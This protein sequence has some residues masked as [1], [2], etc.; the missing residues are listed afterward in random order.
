LL[1]NGSANASLDMIQAAA[2]GIS[3]VLQIASQAYAQAD[4]VSAVEAGRVM[5][6]NIDVVVGALLSFS[7]RVASSARVISPELNITVQ[8]NVSGQLTYDT[9]GAGNASILLPASLSRQSEE[10]GPVT[11]V[12][13]T[14]LTDV[15][16]GALNASDSR[17]GPVVSFSVFSNGSKVTSFEEPLLIALP[18][19]SAGDT[20]RNCVG[21]PSGRDVF[22]QMRTGA[23]PCEASLQCKFWDEMAQEWR[24]EGCE[25]V[26]L[27][28]TD[29]AV[30]CRCTHLTDFISI[31]VPVVVQDTAV[32]LLSLDPVQRAAV[33][34]RCS[35]D[36]EAVLV[37]GGNASGTR[38]VNLTLTVSRPDL[39]YPNYTAWSAQLAP[40]SNGSLVTLLQADGTV[41]DGVPIELSP[42]S[43]GETATG[44]R[45]RATVA[46]NVTAGSTAG[47]CS[48]ISVGVRATVL[49]STAASQ[50]VWGWVPIGMPCAAAGPPAVG[51]LP[52][53]T[54]PMV[55]GEERSV[56]FTGCDY[57]GLAVQHAV[58]TPR[59]ALPDPRS[60]SAALVEL[61]SGAEL[62]VQVVSRGDG[63][64]VAVVRATRLGRTGLILTLGVDETDRV[65]AT[66]ALGALEVEV[67]CPAGLVADPAT[68]TCAC[69]AGREQ[70]GPQDGSAPAQCAACPR[71][72]FKPSVGPG[73]CEACPAG[74]RQ[75]DVAGVSCTPCIPGT[76]QPEDGQASCLLCAARTTSVAPYTECGECDAGTVRDSVKVAAS[77]EA[78]RPCHP[79][80]RCP[81]NAT[82]LPTMVLNPGVWRLAPDS[83]MLDQC[84]P[85]AGTSPCLGGGQ[86]GE[87]GAGYCRPGHSGFRC[88]VCPDG[89]YFDSGTALCTNCHTAARYTLQY[90][91]LLGSPVL[92]WLLL[93][94]IQRR[95]LWPKLN[96]A[97]SDLK[98]ASRGTDLFAKVRI[99]IGFAQVA[100]AAATYSIDVPPA[101]RV[102]LGVLSWFRL[103][104]WGEPFLPHACAGGYLVYMQLTAY[105]P[106]VLIA[107][108]G[109][110]CVGRQMWR[111]SG[112]ATAARL[113][114]L[115]A[116]GPSLAIVTMLCPTVSAA[117]FGALHCRR[118]VSS[119][120]PVEYRSFLWSS[121][122]LECDS[123]EAARLRA[124]AVAVLVV[125]PL[126][127]LV[128]LAVLLGF[129]RDAI[130]RRTPSEL[131]SAC[132]ML[133]TEV[134]L[135]RYWWGLVEHFR[136]LMLTGVLLL[137]PERM[138]FIRL[139]VALFICLS[140]LVLQPMLNPYARADVSA[141]SM[142]DQLVIFVLI[143]GYS[144]IYLFERLRLFLPT[145][146]DGSTAISLVLAFTS[147]EQ[148]AVLIVVVVST[149][150]LIVAVVVLQ[151]WVNGTRNHDF[152]LKETMR[153]PV[154]SIRKEHRFHLFLSHVWSTGQDQVAV[155]KRQIQ[156]HLPDVRIFLDVDDLDDIGALERYIGE[157]SVVLIFL[158]RGYFTSTNCLREVR[159]AMNARKPVVLVLE[160]DV[161]K[162]GYGS[163]EQA[164]QDC[165]ADC[166]QYVF[167]DANGEPRE[168]ILWHRVKEFQLCALK[169]IAGAMLSHSPHYNLSKRKP[170]M[171]LGSAEYE[172]EA[173][174]TLEQVR[175]R[176]RPVRQRVE[177]CLMD[178][179]SFAKL[180]FPASIPS[181][182]V[183]PYNLGAEAVVQDLCDGLRPGFRPT[184]HDT[185][186]SVLR[187]GL[188]ERANSHRN[189]L[190]PNT[191]RMHTPA[192]RIFV[193]YLNADTWQGEAGSALAE[194]VRAARQSGTSIV[195][196]HE[197]DPERGG[198]TFARFFLTT[199]GDLIDDGLFD[200]LAVPM[201][202]NDYRQVSLLM[203]AQA[204]GARVAG[205][206]RK[207]DAR[208]VLGNIQGRLRLRRQ[209][210]GGSGGSGG[211]DRRSVGSGGDAVGGHGVAGAGSSDASRGSGVSNAAP[212][213]SPA[214]GVAEVGRDGPSSSKTKKAKGMST[215]R[216]LVF[217]SA[218]F[219]ASA[220]WAWSTGRSGPQARPEQGLLQ[221]PLPPTSLVVHERVLFPRTRR[222]D[223]FITVQQPNFYRDELIEFVNLD[224]VRQ[225]VVSCECTRLVR[226]SLFK[227]EQAV[228]T[229]E[230]ALLVA[231]DPSGP[232]FERWIVVGANYS[233][234]RQAE[235]VFHEMAHSVSGQRSTNYSASGQ[236]ELLQFEALEGSV[237]GP[238]VKIRL[239]AN[240]WPETG[241]EAGYGAGLLVNIS[242]E[243]AAVDDSEILVEISVEVLA[244]VVPDETVWGNVD[245]DLLCSQADGTEAAS[246]AL[247]QLGG[248]PMVITFG[249]TTNFS[250]T[251]CDVEGLPCSHSVPTE[252]DELP[253]RRSFTAELRN[254][255]T[256]HALPVAVD[257][258]AGARYVAVMRPGRVGV[259]ALDLYLGTG[260]LSRQR[261]TPRAGPLLVEVV[262]P[263]GL[264]VDP[265]SQ[266]C[267]CDR[268]YQPVIPGGAQLLVSGCDACP[269]GQ[270]KT[271][272][273]V[274]A[275]QPCAA[276]T[277]QP[278]TA[279]ASCDDC[280]PG[281]FQPERGRTACDMCPTLTNS[282]A[283][284]TACEQ[285]VE[286]RYRTSLEIAAN[287]DS[288]RPCPAGAS[289]PYGSTILP[290]LFLEPGTWR[291][292]RQT[293]TFELCLQGAGGSTVCTGGPLAGD[294]GDG[295]CALGHTG[296]LCQLCEEDD[297]YFEWQS[298]SC[299][300]CPSTER[301]VFVYG[302]V[303]G[304]PALLLGAAVVAYRRS[305]R[306]RNAFAYARSL[307]DE[308][309]VEAKVKVLIGFVQTVSVMG[310]VY[311]L[312]MPNL[313]RVVLQ[314]L[315]LLYIDVVGG[316]FIPT[317]CM[318]GYY[319]FLLVKACFPIAALVI[320]TAVRVYFWLRL[321]RRQSDTGEPRRWSAART[322]WQCVETIGT[323]LLPLTLWMIIFFCVSIS[324]SIFSA[325]HCRRFSDDSDEQEYR[326]FV[327]ESLDIECPTDGHP[328]SAAFQQLRGLA[329]AL[330]MV[331]PVG[332]LVG[333]AVLLWAIRRQVV[334][335]RPS[336]L[337][338][339]ARVLTRDYRSNYFWWDWAELLRR[340]VLTGF[341]LAVPESVAFLRLVT[342]LLF[343]VLFLVAQ[344]TLRPFKQDSLQAFSSGLQTVTI[345]LLIGATFMYAYQQFDVVL[346][347]GGAAVR[348]QDGRLSPLVS[349][350]VFATIEDLAA[351]CLGVM[352]LLLVLA[353][354]LLVVRIAFTVSKLEILKLSRTR[355]APMLSIRKEH[356]HHL[357][358]SH[359]W[360]TGQDQVAVIKRQLLRMVHGLRIFLDVDDL[361]DIGALEKYVDESMVVLV[362]L[363]RGY[364]CS[365]NCLREIK[366]A[367]AR[368]KPLLLVLET[369][370]TKGG[371]ILA[372]AREECPEELREYVFGPEEKR[373]DV[374]PWHRITVFQLCTLKE[375]M[376]VVLLHTPLYA[377]EPNFVL[378]LDSDLDLQLLQFRKP[379]LLY[380]SPN[381]PGCAAAAKELA[382]HSTEADL[383]VVHQAPEALGETKPDPPPDGTGN[384][385]VVP[386]DAVA[387]NLEVPPS[388]DEENE[389]AATAGEPSLRKRSLHGLCKASASSD[390]GPSQP[391]LGSASGRADGGDA[392]AQSSHRVWRRRSSE[393]DGPNPRKEVFLLYLNSQ[394]FTGE[395]GRALALEVGRALK[396]NTS[397]VML[398]ENDQ[399][400]G[401]C[402]FAH[403]FNTTP[404]ELI[405]AGL[406]K[407]IALGLYPVPH[408]DVSLALV[409][410]ALGA[411]KKSRIKMPS[412]HGHPASGREGEGNWMRRISSLVGRRLGLGMASGA[413]QVEQP[414]E[415]PP[416]QP[417][418]QSAPDQA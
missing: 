335:R 219:P 299:A 291:I 410:Q 398:H 392:L 306:A 267:T 342:A 287:A 107:C 366:A 338:H 159:E 126:G 395:L 304:I 141:F 39:G 305:L 409:A 407:P 153:P 358:L 347:N 76:Y 98:L 403:F 31:K 416:P 133:W 256:G 238:G 391:S 158:S 294:D 390:A 123:D 345:V 374:I 212:T 143:L 331:W 408:R 284:F 199:P 235:G 336:K 177:L 188:Q 96:A 137:F 244:T 228:L 227:T 243:N 113:G 192:G 280:L 105:F 68:G 155:I 373:R 186:P 211:D 148:I 194:E 108:I 122:G 404:H 44:R 376:R 385:T 340:L 369:N 316:L 174:A 202:A 332:C 273:G 197:N 92:A 110:G 179:V 288:C 307:W 169:L 283:P 216:G 415:R 320:A 57:E 348:W 330:I 310:T 69:A 377:G 254:D 8:S 298:A 231:E 37:K 322:A 251:A 172:D 85:A 58:P 209:A 201:H 115:N 396:S 253:D 45:Y 184:V 90:I 222:L 70:I 21:Q 217:G 56:A 150:A 189:I 367:R 300:R 63:R 337:S 311:S 221:L 66:P 138:A 263:A 170:G 241:F 124:T 29:G 250:F 193:L 375:I 302:L 86:A 218:F 97:L 329:I 151:Q 371:L 4:P 1:G 73:A 127:S 12:M 185:A 125:W 46:V 270:F 121:P 139:I 275:C 27:N 95:R 210:D 399:Q 182:C 321:A 397:I 206:R 168:A 42:V 28:G 79:L 380:A 67:R 247:Q 93:W 164:A 229:R 242:H 78:C 324:S 145:E 72:F 223:E 130:S 77:Q 156:L 232:R 382:V 87:D 352:L 162:G 381:N 252:R 361:E 215:L 163:L 146:A 245:P 325:L 417:P 154:L 289:C 3:N 383:K 389:A 180:Y 364:F 100:S 117:A 50:T 297:H 400:K 266:T 147:T 285:C 387:I 19:L 91:A 414:P 237:S 208:T 214:A 187:R 166:R 204:I 173:A 200:Q 176:G 265:L 326:E 64:Y 34:C 118:V 112:S 255:T 260:P 54:L 271:E 14:S 379:V 65:D 362:F 353:L 142:A 59:K 239:A 360:S 116:L 49:A 372:E 60:F 393:Q 128:G 262:C 341:V 344:T 276:G 277:V 225:S 114:L 246:V 111:S 149:L 318:G 278:S 401:G 240:A 351:L 13:W 268:G 132:K 55:L 406:Y 248:R 317:A 323:E 131:S 47:E 402:S 129:I 363:S 269:G 313:Y 207:I 38:R 30:G 386:V 80:A 349:V 175:P 106:L 9:S 167:C 74:S 309:S 296:P 334:A 61:A 249:A 71:G 295:Y 88:E 104:I 24:E 32:E 120:D 293:R 224:A 15:H 234:P 259:F 5:R 41:S 136:R 23:S 7:G 261:A 264:V 290:T 161:T 40:G 355:A 157:S 20:D 109:A 2:N 51:L 394:T 183:S 81:L 84:A 181:L 319:N 152:V 99:L 103:D 82:T 220:R 328:A 388:N 343:S 339:A 101:L 314:A 405:D 350:F 48:H 102:L 279:S 312:T 135:C 327:I 359:V 418:A 354:V 378:Y 22:G 25:T 365:R 281:T 52:D 11:V 233:L 286:G 258:P 191:A 140:F 315:E 89:R 292:S 83:H 196:L 370:D 6:D 384:E 26:A 301:Y 35:K 368:D 213:N 203:A 230:V 62:P 198:C 134:R 119:S 94:Q 272:L 10:S 333:L 413:P 75:P 226:L 236:A 356:R 33:H 195:M 308:Y 53:W 165:P 412:W 190:D 257:S 178:E 346:A 171:N 18:V 160:G 274:A 411:G 144:F 282:T 36:L 16:G 357:F 303:L 17:A 43:L 205:S